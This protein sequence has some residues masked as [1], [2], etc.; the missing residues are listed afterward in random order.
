[1]MG[2]REK[3]LTERAATYKLRERKQMEKEKKYI[4]EK[5]EIEKSRD[6]LHKI[7]T[8]IDTGRKILNE[9]REKRKKWE[10]SM[11]KCQT[12]YELF[13]EEIQ[14]KLSQEITKSKNECGRQFWLRKRRWK[15]CR[16]N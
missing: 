13:R 10:E 16:P 6:E 15:I 8:K 9:L 2:E 12:D 7:Q 14:Q 11:T 1:M 3:E 4:K 5:K